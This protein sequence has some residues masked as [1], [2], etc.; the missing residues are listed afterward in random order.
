MWSDQ[1]PDVQAVADLLQHCAEEA[2][3]LRFEPVDTRGADPAVLHQA[4][5]ARARRQL[6]LRHSE[7]DRVL[8]QEVRA[9]DDLVRAANLLIERLRE[10]YAL[11][12]PEAVRLEPDA[13]R[14][15]SLVAEH[16]ERAA[17]FAALRQA[18]L[19]QTSLGSE[20]D[21]A[22]LEALRGFAAALTAVHAS[23]RGLEARI[24]ALM[25]EVAPNVA[26]AAG[27]VL[28]ARL[29]AQ[30]GSLERLATY[31]AGTVQLLGAETALFRHLKEGARP[32]KHGLLFQHP[33]VHQAP[34]WQ[35]GAL[36]RA[37]A[38]AVALAAK[39][40]AF[41]HRDVRADVERSLEAD[42]ARIA[43]TR[44]RARARDAPAKGRGPGGGAR[45]DP[46]RP[47]GGRGGPGRGPPG[48]SRQDGR[49]QDRRGPRQ[50]GRPGGPDGDRAGGSAGK[51]WRPGKPGRPRG[52][53]RDGPAPPPGRGA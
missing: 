34:P 8:A 1:A 25:D 50:A 15:A 42:Y 28:G 48:A 6:A 35:R 22:D 19:A 49:G 4:A 24:R 21:P 16:G 14:L 26:A 10:W 36:A 53:K 7:K 46:A 23:W 38:S 9:V 52:P 37:I 30:A 45:Q 43:R 33:K 20:L 29:V 13:E 17:V 5:L 27:A 41:T 47:G 39:A 18:D 40:D 12:A 2:T 44:A 32:P 31:P 51:A 11:H 3:S